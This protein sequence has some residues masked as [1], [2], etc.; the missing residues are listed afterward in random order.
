MKPLKQQRELFDNHIVHYGFPAHIHSDQGVNIESKLI[1]ELCKIA[2]VENHKQHLIILWK[3]DR[4]KGLTKPYS[5]CLGLFKKTRKVTGRHMTLVWS[6]P[7]IPHFMTALGFSPYFLMFGRHPRLA[8]DA[9]FGLNSDSL[10]STSYTEFI[11]KLSNRLSLAYHKA[12]E[13]SKKAGT[14][15]KLNYDLICLICF[16]GVS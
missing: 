3:K 9:F 13:V 16:P 4:W 11:R 8:I 1:K 15:H 10:N 2:G 5:K 12:L 14:K 6:M 7:T